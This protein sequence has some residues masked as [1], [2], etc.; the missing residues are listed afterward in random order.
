MLPDPLS[1]RPLELRPGTSSTKTCGDED[2]YI[3]VCYAPNICP[4]E[5]KQ[6]GKS[7]T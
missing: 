3:A 7:C 5:R 2:Q 4:T 6:D 1:R